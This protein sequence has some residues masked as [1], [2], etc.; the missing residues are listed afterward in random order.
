MSRKISNEE[1]TYLDPDA[2]N[3][4]KRSASST[5]ARANNSVCKVVGIT[6]LNVEIEG[7]VCD[8]EFLLIDHEDKGGLLVLDWFMRT[9]ASLNPS[10]NCL[11]FPNEIV[12]STNAI[13]SM[14]FQNSYNNAPGLLGRIKTR[15]FSKNSYR[16]VY[17]DD[18]I[19]HSK[20]VKDHWQ[21]IKGVAE[22]LGIEN[23]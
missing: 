14:D 23:D 8:Y 10:L 20:S 4:I 15:I 22:D 12:S 16:V 9:G 17:L 11:K 7:G 21:H 6:S 18:I 1:K 5:L 3:L 13:V 19:I 2:N